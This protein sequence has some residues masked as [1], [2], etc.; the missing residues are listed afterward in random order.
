MLGAIVGAKVGDFG[1]TNGFLHKHYL[2]SFTEE[3]TPEN[4]YKCTRLGTATGAD[5]STWNRQT[6][7]QDTCTI[8][9]P[10]E[11]RADGSV[12]VYHG[13]STWAARLESIPPLIYRKDQIK[14]IWPANP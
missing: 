10:A 11:L 8:E 5:M 7:R 6:N 14:L 9:A 4:I 2:I 3:Q 1:T 12:A 13:A